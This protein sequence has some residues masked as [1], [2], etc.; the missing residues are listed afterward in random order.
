MKK[1]RVTPLLQLVPGFS[2]KS[3]LIEFALLE[4]QGLE[5]VAVRAAIAEATAAICLHQALAQPHQTSVRI[6]SL[7]VA[8]LH[9][10]WQMMQTHEGD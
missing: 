6:Q 7:D 2:A 8:R 10:S 5:L 9:L 4:E 1:S 3:G